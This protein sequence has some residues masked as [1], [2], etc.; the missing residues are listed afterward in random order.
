MQQQGS[1]V[2]LTELK[3]KLGNLSEKELVGPK[4]QALLSELRNILAGLESAPGIDQAR[5]T[6][7]NT[8]VGSR[9]SLDPMVQKVLIGLIGKLVI[10]PASNDKPTSN[11]NELMGKIPGLKEALSDPNVSAPMQEAGSLPLAA[12]TAPAQTD[13]LEPVFAA[14]DNAGAD[15]EAVVEQTGKETAA[16]ESAGLNMRELLGFFLQESFEQVETL[17]NGL[18]EL[19]RDGA[20]LD[21]VNE[22]FR[23]AHTLKGA[24]GTMG[25][26]GI[27]K[28]T[29]LAEDVLDGLRQ[30]KLQVSAALVDLLLGV[31]DRVKS[32][33]ADIQNGGEGNSDV[34]DLVGKLAAFLGKTQAAETL[35]KSGSE[36]QA[37][38]GVFGLDEREM[39]QIRELS[40]AGHNIFDV[41]VKFSAKILMPSVRA[42]MAV[43][44]VE[45]YGTVL[46]TSPATEELRQDS[47][48]EF[49]LLLAT[50]K[51]S[52]SVEKVIL[53]V[54]EIEGVECK[55]FEATETP[56]QVVDVA[57]AVRLQDQSREFGLSQAVG[58]GTAVTPTGFKNPTIR[59]PA[60]KLDDLLNLVGEMVI[61]R[62]RLV[63]VGDELKISLPQDHL[64]NSLNETT[65]YLGRLMNELQE[66]VMSM[67]MVPIGHVYSRFPRLIRDLARKTHKD[68]ELLLFGEETELDKTIIQEIGDPLMHIL[69][70]CV[71]HGIES[72][73]ERVAAGK[74]PAG[75]ITIEA[76]H[77]GSHIIV[78]VSD[79]G[80]GI[81]LN[82]V[83]AKAVAKG[84]VS[85]TEDLS[86]KEAANLI[87]LP[88]LS[89]AS[90]VTDVSGRG[91][92]MDVVKRS[93]VNLGG[94]I[95]IETSPGK[96]TTMIIRLP[97]T[98]AIIQALLVDVG[99]QVYALPLASV[100]ETLRIP[101]EDLKSVGGRAVIQLRGSTLPLISLHEH[102]D[103]EPGD[104]EEDIVY[105]VVVG[106]GER[107]LG[108]VVD[109]LQG[110]Q[111]IVIKSLGDFLGTVQGFSGATIGGD[112][113]VILILD[114]ASLVHDTFTVNRV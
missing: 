20:R 107:R 94:M 11:M 97:L 47:H 55:K 51:D 108:L 17:S 81:D 63:S 102:F 6:N 38:E 4:V 67:R 79:D 76:F 46:R 98:L 15:A 37:A 58:S 78:S 87:F 39:S 21:L 91:V 71:D 52:Q 114:V 29:H 60:E 112:G 56:V 18:V 72:Q 32:I 7:L 113:K 57:E 65:V 100:L 104:S 109:G 74:S 105:V 53:Q 22:L 24:S 28:I 36:G 26:S 103:L 10:N 62:T 9:Q 13:P 43:R 59:V 69:R 75:K 85:Q 96:G 14:E 27:V 89:T 68:V 34:S 3:E 8:F 16:A 84:F 1:L 70:N 33:L 12:D 23:T 54:S 93:L 111:E 101:K 82:A 44:R 92:G 110:Q 90:K 5:L 66:S 88:G 86:D 77:E 31:A 73:A 40:Q 30:G 61:A 99:S 106:F 50:E 95:D 80:K 25:Y 49:H 83:R 42:V 35:P 2:E 64:V 41:T 19:E 45:K 48:S